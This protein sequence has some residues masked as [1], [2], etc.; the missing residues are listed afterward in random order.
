MGTA[1]SQSKPD[2]LLRPFMP[3]LE[4]LRG[5]AIAGV[6]CLHGLHSAFHD[7]HFGRWGRLV[8]S[9]SQAGWVG[10]NL[11]FVFSRFLITGILLD[12]RNR[13]DYYKRFYIRRALRILPAY[14]ALLVLLLLLGQASLAYVGLGFVYLANVT[15]FFGVAQYYGP[16][17]S[18]AVEEHFYLLWPKMIRRV[19]T[20][21]V[22]IAAF[23]IFALVPV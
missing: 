15:N 12:S 10:V 22:A 11:F 4:S 2:P 6:V 9:S 19:R 23:A 21:S 5:I 13:S 14:Y 17:W 16:L 18:L 3:E 20:K 8:L 1:L 7:Y